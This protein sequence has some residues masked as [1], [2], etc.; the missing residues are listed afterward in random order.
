MPETATPN[1]RR[2]F[3]TSTCFNDAVGKH[4][5]EWL[6]SELGQMLHPMLRSTQVGGWPGMGAPMAGHLARA[7]AKAVH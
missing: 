3:F 4:V 7:T 1:L 6:R 5:H 2:Q